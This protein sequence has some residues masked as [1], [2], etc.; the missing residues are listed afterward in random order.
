MFIY[1][2]TNELL[3]VPFGGTTFK[4]VKCTKKMEQSCQAAIIKFL[5]EKYQ[6]SMR[7]VRYCLNEER[8]PSFADNLKSDYQKLIQKVMHAINEEKFNQN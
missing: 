6:I 2:I 5:A 3:C 4:S 8:N 1:L 7:Y